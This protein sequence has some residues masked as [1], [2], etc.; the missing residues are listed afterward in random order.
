MR[1]VAVIALAA[2][3]P[4]LKHHSSRNAPGIVD[5]DAP[6][7]QENADPAWYEV[8]RD[9]GE[10]A[11]GIAPGMG[12]QFGAGRISSDFTV[13][14]TAQLHVSYAPRESSLGRGAV[15]Y[16]WDSWGA[17]L[18]W[19][20]FQVTEDD[21]PNTFMDDEYY[22]GP[23]FAEVTRQWLF[24]SASAGLVLYPTPGEVASGRAEGVDAGGQISLMAMPFGVRARYVADTGFEIFAGY[25]FEI[26]Y[27]VTWSR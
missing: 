25:Q 1:F 15:G 17:T 20:I 26:P 27:A 18:G 21:D 16:P 2:C 5:I 19:G 6:P 14:M 8:P 13:E 10:H 22:F 24:F 4:G 3:G 9:P 11:V 7:A 23:I 12:V